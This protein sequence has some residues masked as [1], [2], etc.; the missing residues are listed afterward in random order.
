LLQVGGGEA[1]TVGPGAPTCVD[2]EVFSS[3][4]FF[5][6]TTS[7]SISNTTS[8]ALLSYFALLSFSSISLPY[9]ERFFQKK[10][11]SQVRLTVTRPIGDL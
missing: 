4:E 6:I 11:T 8:F 2:R 7:R 5:S 9:G 1:H 3:N 10:R